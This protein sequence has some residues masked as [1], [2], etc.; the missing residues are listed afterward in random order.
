[1]VR[2]HLMA[3]SPSRYPAPAV[4]YP[5]VRSRQLGS[6]LLVLSALGL[7][8]CLAWWR[9]AGVPLAAVL[10]ALATWGG[11]TVLAWRFWWLSPAGVLVWDGRNWALDRPGQGVIVGVLAVHLDVQRSV[12][13]RLTPAHGAPWWLWLE[14]SWDATRWMDV[15]R[16]LY[17]RPR[18][19]AA[20][21]LAETPG[22]AP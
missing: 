8:V 15:R 11:A 21:N 17:S 9:W 7:L 12:W 19:G 5:V 4:R 3:A 1:M 10:A 13:V 22:R 6:L 14:Q 2:P 18:L 16:A 20:D